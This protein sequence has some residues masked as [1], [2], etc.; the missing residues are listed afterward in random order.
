VSR[1]PGQALADFHIFRLV[2]DA[3]GC[4][5]MFR[6][7]SSPEAVF[8]IMKDLSRGQPCDIT[9]IADYGM[10]DREGGVQWPLPEGTP[11][12]SGERRLFED[13]KFFHPDGRARLIVED[14]RPIPEATSR[15]YPLTLLTGRGSSSQWHTQT[16]TSKSAVLRRLSPQEIYVEV[17][18][19]DAEALGMS[20]NEWINVVSRRA[21]IAARAFVTQNV[22]PGQIFIPMHYEV[23]NKLTFPAFDPYS[24]Q[25]AY[26]ASAV[27]LERIQSTA[28]P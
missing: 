14:V 17:N 8:Q 19:A 20:P 18:P 11:L 4:G 6:R 16:R 24:R 28:A 5:D 25:P 15:D 10:L 22:K 13:G 12:A 27:R 21:T 1:A 3:W 7:W 23:M 2:A 26:K 9:G